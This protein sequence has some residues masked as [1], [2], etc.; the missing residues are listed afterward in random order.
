MIFNGKL[1]EELSELNFVTI[2][3]SN[4]SFSRSNIEPFIHCTDSLNLPCA[5][6]ARHVEV[7]LQFLKKNLL[8]HS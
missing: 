4:H 8:T 2:F 3:L 5:N 6:N 1:I 7:L